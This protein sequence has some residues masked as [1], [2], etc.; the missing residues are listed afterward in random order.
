MTI[1]ST[2]YTVQLVEIILKKGMKSTSG[3]T[4]TYL[5]ECQNGILYIPLIRVC[6]SSKTFVTVNLIKSFGLKIV[7]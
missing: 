3:S 1:G 2:I 4:S 6:V 5:R 7:Y